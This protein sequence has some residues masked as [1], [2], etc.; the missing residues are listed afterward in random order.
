MEALG[1][2]GMANKNIKNSPG[3]HCLPANERADFSF[4][5]EEN[6]SAVCEEKRRRFIG[7]AAH[8][9]CKN[10][11]SRRPRYGSSI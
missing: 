7:T 11:G 6:V 2:F 8:I 1:F 10:S 5:L 4:S 9:N 3:V